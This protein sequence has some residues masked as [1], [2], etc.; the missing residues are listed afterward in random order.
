MTEL[1]SVELCRVTFFYSVTF[2]VLLLLL[3]AAVVTF[4]A[5]P[6]RKGPARQF[7][8]TA[9]LSAPVE[10]LGDEPQIEIFCRQDGGVALVRR[11]LRD[12][13]MSGK[14][15]L[16]VKIIGFN[17]TIIEHSTPGNPADGPATEGTFLLDFFARERYHIYYKSEPTGHMSAFSLNVRPGIRTT[18][19]L[20]M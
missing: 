5:R 18:H 19:L 2:Y 11:G 14:L 9:I 13:Y 6:A 8:P 1:I 15:T 20:K 4:S 12:I 17:V 3:G 16:S 7:F 10:G